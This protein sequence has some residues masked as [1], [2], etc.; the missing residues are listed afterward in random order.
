MERFTRDELRQLGPK[1]KTELVEFPAY[2]GSVLVRELSAA[3]SMAILKMEDEADRGAEMVRRS[4]YDPEKGTTMFGPDEWPDVMA[5]WPQLLLVRIAEA[6]ARLSALDV[7]TAET[8][9]GNSS[10]TPS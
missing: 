9:R 5:E 6:A 7:S 8:L 4:L 3:D 10:E 2:G 1:R